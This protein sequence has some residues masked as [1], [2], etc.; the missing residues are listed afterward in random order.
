MRDLDYWDND[1]ISLFGVFEIKLL[2]LSYI[3]FLR[4]QNL[5]KVKSKV[6]EVD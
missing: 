6:A 5:E 3:Y 4:N 1:M 2:Y